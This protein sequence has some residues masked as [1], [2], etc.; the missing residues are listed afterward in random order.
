MREWL[1][2]PSSSSSFTAL[3]HNMSRLWG[4]GASGGCGKES[5]SHNDSGMHFWKR[6]FSGTYML[7]GFLN[8]FLPSLRWGCIQITSILFNGF[9]FYNTLIIPCKASPRPHCCTPIRLGP[10]QALWFLSVEAQHCCVPASILPISG[11]DGSICTAI[12]AH[13]HKCTALCECV[14]SLYSCTLPV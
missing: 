6:I 1:R 7:H 12:Y 8:L 10:H 2:S 5:I 14:H 3:K 13:M 4:E 11:R 9:F